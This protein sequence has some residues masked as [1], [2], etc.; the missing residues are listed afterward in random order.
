ML[1]LLSSVL[2]LDA[3]GFMLVWTSPQRFTVQFFLFP[4]LLW[5]KMKISPLFTKIFFLSSNFV[6]AAGQLKIK[7][8]PLVP[9]FC[10]CIFVHCFESAKVLFPMAHFLNTQFLLVSFGFFPRVFLGGFCWCF[11]LLFVCFGFVLLGFLIVWFFSA[12]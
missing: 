12:S 1:S 3:A 11:L 10:C 4:L 8:L 9:T 5:Q 7:L 2:S 6:V